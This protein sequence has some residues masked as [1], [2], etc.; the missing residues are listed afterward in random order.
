MA[1]RFGSSGSSNLARTTNLP[2]ATNYTIAGWFMYRGTGQSDN[3]NTI[4]AYG[5]SGTNNY[6]FLYCKA[7]ST[8]PGFNV[9]GDAPGTVG[10]NY[11]LTADKW[12]YIAMIRNSASSWLRGYYVPVDNAFALEYSYVAG[13]STPSTS[14][15]IGNNAAWD[16]WA[17]QRLFNVMVWGTALT[18]AELLAQRWSFRPVVQ[19]SNLNGWYP[20]WSQSDRNKDFSGNG[21]DW[22]ETGTLANED[23]APVSLGMRPRIFYSIGVSSTSLI[24]QDANHAHTADNIVLVTA[25]ALAIQDSAHSHVVDNIAIS[26]HHSIL[27]QDSAHGHTAE[28]I[29]IITLLWPFTDNFTGTYDSVWN[30]TKWETSAESSSPGSL[31]S[32]EEPTG[33]DVTSDT[34]GSG[35]VVER[36]NEQSYYGTYCAKCSTTN[37]GAKAQIRHST[38]VSNWANVPVSNPGEHVWWKG[39]IYIPSATANAITGSEYID[40]AGYYVSSTG[41][42]F[43]LRLTEGAKLEMRGPGDSGQGGSKLWASMPL[44]QW[45]E[46]EIGL[47]SQDTG[48]LNRAFAVVI[49]GDYFGWFTRG[50]GTQNYDRLAVG[51]I[52]TNSNDDLVVY[53]DEMNTTT[54]NVNPE[55]S[56]NRPTGNSALLDYRNQ[57]GENVGYHYTTWESNSPDMNA[58]YGLSATSRIQSGINHERM[59]SLANG[60]SM[61]VINWDNGS[62]PSWPPTGNGNFFAPMIGFHKSIE[63][64]ENLEIVPIYRPGD[65]TVDLVYESWT[66]SPVEYAE[67]QLPLDG[68]GHRIPGQGDKIYVT[69]EE[70]SATNIHVVVDY[71]DASADTWYSSVIDDNRNLSNV[72]GVNFLDGDHLAVT[73]TIDSGQY[74]I[75]SQEIGTLGTAPR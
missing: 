70:V 36:S 69:W 17:N 11:L 52:G 20:M 61:L 12:Y 66:I 1:L 38:W 29:T 31:E 54:T 37:S 67:W 21:N 43:Y 27:V 57:S 51:I 42:G 15:R 71:Y 28:N 33:W 19:N 46:I 63:L 47:W 10:G 40:L 68:S 74:S 8:S 13:P 24:I 72:S 34:S 50:V 2:S 9:Y 53:V 59:P 44:D 48:D 7:G 35:S 26:Q 16:E 65:G 41:A 3:W 6:N 73:N 45:V 56:D 39:Y 62:T 22:T 23:P 60:W 14:L 4:F 5:S 30:S 49:N 58:T 75:I 32:F 55:G 64:E 25:G 18:E